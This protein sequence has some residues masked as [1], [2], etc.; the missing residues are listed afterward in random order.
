MTP[1]KGKHFVTLAPTVLALSAVS[2]LWLPQVHADLLGHWALDD[3]LDD[4]DEIVAA[5]SGPEGYDGDL[6]DF[7]DPPW[8]LEDEAVYGGA[9]DFGGSSGTVQI[10]LQDALP[11]GNAPRTLAAWVFAPWSA[12][13]KF[14]SYGSQANG[15]SFDFTVEDHDGTP[16]VWFRHWGGNIRFPGA[17]YG[18]WM[19]FAAVVPEDAG[20]TSDLI[21]YINGEEMEGIRGDGADRVLDTGLSNLVIGGRSDG[22]NLFE[23]R[24]DDVWLFDEALDEDEI[25]EILEGGPTEMPPVENRF[26]RGDGNSTGD[27]NISDAVFVL[28]SLFGGGERPQCED[29]AD[30]DDNGTLNITD[31]VSILSFLFGGQGALPPPHETCGP[32]PTDDALGCARQPEACAG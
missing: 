28:N 26:V 31:G 11:I 29:A 21:V 9:I 6:I 16:H 18:E 30:A 24:V 12:D 17:A 8:V 5:D 4:P 15:M 22:P 13:Q 25:V 1:K 2:F 10:S 23:G 14:L 19:H 3:G 32:D 7:F 20:M 27:V